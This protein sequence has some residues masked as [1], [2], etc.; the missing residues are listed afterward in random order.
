M[1]GPDSRTTTS[2]SLDSTVLTTMTA[3]VIKEEKELVRH[4]EDI[5]V[6]IVR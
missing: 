5:T 6:M 4:K 2:P 3:T 1:G